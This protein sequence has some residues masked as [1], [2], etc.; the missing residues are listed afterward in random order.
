[1]SSSIKGCRR[2][3]KSTS[4]KTF[5]DHTPPVRLREGQPGMTT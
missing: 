5:I 4:G 2:A 3:I 1:M